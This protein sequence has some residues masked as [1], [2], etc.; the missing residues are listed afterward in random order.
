MARELSLRAYAN[1]ELVWAST[2]DAMRCGAVRSVTDFAHGFELSTGDVES[3]T[4][5]S[6]Y[7]L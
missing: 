7:R 5:N 2:S 3:F 6:V 4:L 1:S